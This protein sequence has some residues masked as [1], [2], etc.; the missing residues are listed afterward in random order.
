MSSEG[1][2]DE[3][4][5][6]TPTLKRAV[7]LLSQSEVLLAKQVHRLMLTDFHTGADIAVPMQE[8]GE[9]AG[10]VLTGNKEGET[11]LKYRYNC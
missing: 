2:H 6:K 10:Q 8:K 5:T 3:Q 7:W 11:L 4:K 1:S 9:G